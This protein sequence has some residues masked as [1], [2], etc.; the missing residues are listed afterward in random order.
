MNTTDIARSVINATGSDSASSALSTPE[1]SNAHEYG[2]VA[3]AEFDN[4][5]ADD[6]QS[7][8]RR[9]AAA[10]LTTLD[11]RPFVSTKQGMVRRQFDDNGDPTR[12]A[13][14]EALDLQAWADG[15]KADPRDRRAMQAH[16]FAKDIN[17]GT[18][19]NSL[20]SGGEVF[21]PGSDEWRQSGDSVIDAIARRSEV[22]KK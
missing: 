20:P 1:G 5:I 19:A 4:Y 6:P 22:L 15:Q 10:A 11:A 8:T 17:N 16:A 14:R 13:A 2:D 7:F 18:M 21:E 9:A 3:G 12:R